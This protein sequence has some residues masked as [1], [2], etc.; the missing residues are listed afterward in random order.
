MNHLSADSVIPNRDDSERNAG[1]HSDE[2]L[3]KSFQE[4]DKKAFEAIFRRYQGRIYGYLFHLVRDQALAEEVFQEAFFHLFRRASQFDSL[5]T[6][7]SWF[8]RVAHNRAIDFLRENRERGKHERFEEE[9][10]AL[11]PSPEDLVL[12]AE[13]TRFLGR[14]LQMLSEEHRSVLLLRFKEGLTYE[15]VAEVI[16]CPVGTAKSRTHHAIRKLRELMEKRHD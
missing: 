13:S 6:F 11:A 5:R 2:E 14:I 4:G 10:S 3:I 7:R 16:G 12:E 1:E 8:F 15:E 9:F